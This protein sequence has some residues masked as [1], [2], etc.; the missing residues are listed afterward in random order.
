M[1]QFTLTCG[2]LTANIR[3]CCTS[4][5]A[6]ILLPRVRQ[7]VGLMGVKRLKNAANAAGFAMVNHDDFE[8]Q[9][10]LQLSTSAPSEQTKPHPTYYSVAGFTDRFEGSGKATA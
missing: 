2:F 8:D 6:T 3:N 4:N 9:T 10:H 1:S 7:G 5:F